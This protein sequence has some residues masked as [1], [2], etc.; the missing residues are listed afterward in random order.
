MLIV[1]STIE[2]AAPCLVEVDPYLPLSFKTYSEVLPGARYFRIGN[3]DTSLLEIGIA[4]SSMAIRKVSLVS[5]D[6]IVNCDQRTAAKGI[7]ETVGLPVV[8]P[9]SLRGNRTDE[10][11]EFGVCLCGDEFHIDWSQGKSLSAVVRF[12]KARFYLAER[13]LCRITFRELSQSQVDLLG[14]RLREGRKNSIAS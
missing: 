14:E 7:Q 10:H 9:A 5:F 13:E 12:Q 4:P 2:V 6:K 8:C 11:T 3:F 1:A